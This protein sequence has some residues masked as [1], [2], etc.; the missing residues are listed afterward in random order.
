M[1][2]FS[3]VVD[4]WRSKW[5]DVTHYHSFHESLFVIKFTRQSELIATGT[6]SERVVNVSD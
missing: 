6:G 2:H 1:D 5:V 3:S 4:M